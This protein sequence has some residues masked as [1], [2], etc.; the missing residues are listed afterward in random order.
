MN[1]YICS[2]TFQETVGNNSQFPPSLRQLICQSV[3]QVPIDDMGQLLSKHETDPE[4]FDSRIESNLRNISP[5]AISINANQRISNHTRFNSDIIIDKDDFSVCLEIEKGYMSR[6]EFDILKM[7]AF[8]SNVLL[9]EDARK[10]VFGAFIVPADNVVAS[11]ISGNSNE[12]S[13]KYLARLSR[14]VAQ[15]QLPLLED[16]LIVGYSTSEL[17]TEVKPARSPKP[18]SDKGTVSYLIE[19]S[20]GLV[21]SETIRKKLRGYPLEIVFRLRDELMSR[22][23]GLREKLNFNSRYLGY[24]NGN[25]SDALYVYI[26]KRQLVLDIR[27]SKEEAESLREQRF[28]VNPKNN[29]QCRAGWLTGV[30][31]PHDTKKLDVIVGLASLALEG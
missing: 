26:Q 2:M 30:S 9:Q 10:R 31:V 7:Q 12:S 22:F 5:A 13:Y 20:S 11:H 23:P 17:S 24:A 4:N 1:L 14:L 8:A 19:G 21:E 15:I 16:I 27:V 29:F 28:K 6:F 3:E 25:R 18:K